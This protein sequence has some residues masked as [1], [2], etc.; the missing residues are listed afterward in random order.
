M[1]DNVCPKCGNPYTYVGDV[2][3]DPNDF[4]CRCYREPMPYQRLSFNSD[5]AN[6]YGVI[7]EQQAEIAR[8]RAALAEAE[9]ERDEVY[10]ISDRAYQLCKREKERGDRAYDYLSIARK[11]RDDARKWARYLYKRYKELVKYTGSF[12]G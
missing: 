11:E 1:S 2:F 5:N 9:R 6:L 10:Q 4:V 7:S 12:S 8:L 3:G